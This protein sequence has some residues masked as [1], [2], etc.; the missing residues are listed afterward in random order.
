M[1]STKVV[2]GGHSSSG[3]YCCVSSLLDRVVADKMGISIL[4]FL[5]VLTLSNDI[6]QQGQSQS[7]G[8]EV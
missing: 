7:D 5:C 3:P 6:V 8:E 4:P 1:Q 2:L